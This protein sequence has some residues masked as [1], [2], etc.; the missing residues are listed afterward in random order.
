MQYSSDNNHSLEELSIPVKITDCIFMGDE[1]IAHVSPPTSRTSSGYH[2]IKS[3]MSST[4]QADSVPT[5][6]PSRA[7]AFSPSIGP[8]IKYRTSQN[9]MLSML[10]SASSK[11][12]SKNKAPS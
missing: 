11:K 10:L 2:S 4:V 9:K 12:L 5:T 6:P 7:C 1:A 3:P 8:K